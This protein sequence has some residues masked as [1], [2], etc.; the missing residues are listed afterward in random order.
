MSEKIPQDIN[1]RPEHFIIEDY[2]I[3]FMQLGL[4]LRNEAN[5]F[6]EIIELLKTHPVKTVSEYLESE[7]RSEN[8]AKKVEEARVYPEKMKRLTEIAGKINLLQSADEEKFKKLVDE[9]I[10]L[11][12]NKKYSLLF[13]K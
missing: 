2:A 6:E 10:M 9:A 3:E 11:L 13:N 1:Y 7:K 5:T 4:L 12:K 8:Y